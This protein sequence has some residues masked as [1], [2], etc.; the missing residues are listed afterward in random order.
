MAL[1]SEQKTEE[2]FIGVP[3]E[4]RNLIGTFGVTVTDLRPAGKVEIDGKIYDAL[5][6]YG[7][8]IT[9]ETKVSVTAYGTGQILVDE[10]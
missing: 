4:Q 2:G 8:F 1:K 3:T 7:K 5:A 9:K 10:I 6:N